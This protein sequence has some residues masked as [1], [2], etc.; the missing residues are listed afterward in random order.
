MQ[1]VTSKCLVTS[2]GIVIPSDN[3]ALASK[4]AAVIEGCNW[5]YFNDVVNGYPSSG[6]TLYQIGRGSIT[7]QLPQPYLLDSMKLC[8]SNVSSYNIEVS[9][10]KVNWTR[11]WEDQIGHFVAESNFF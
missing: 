8:L 11:I 2:T 1:N 10:D 9:T 5:H 7:V 3:V 4:N 6:H